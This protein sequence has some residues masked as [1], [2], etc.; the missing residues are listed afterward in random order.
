MA[1]S[2]LAVV[3][4]FPEEG[5]PSMD[6]CANMLLDQL[7]MSPNLSLAPAR[8][9]P[10]FCRRF[11]CFPG[12]G[13]KPFFFNADRLCNRHWDFPRFLKGNVSRFEF[14]HIVDHSYAH[15]VHELP[16][17]RTGVYC[18]D[19]DAFRCLLRPDLEPRSRWFRRLARQKL[20]GLQRAAVVFH[21]TLSVRQEIL[22][23]GLVESQRLVHAPNGVCPEYMTNPRPNDRDVIA[24][25]HD[26][27]YLLHVG[28]C[29]PRKRIDVLLDVFAAVRRQHPELRLVKVGGPWTSTQQDQIGR[30]GIGRSIV[31]FTDVDRSSLAALYRQAAVLL[32]P[33]EA[34]GFGLPVIEGLACGSVVIASDLPVLREVG[35]DAVLYCPV[36]DIASWTDMVHSVIDRPESVPG[37]SVRLAR[38]A[39]YSWQAQAR[40]IADAYLRLARGG[41]SRGEASAC[42][43]PS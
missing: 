12:F 23:H 30:L 8:I 42:A 37:K 31:Q 3:C 19:L 40:T 36:G 18:H 21:T 7:V 6:L 33:S 35:G 20:D 24:D 14:F 26:S 34:E 5:W 39:R 25:L 22:D 28:S 2:R 29:I 4:D 9:C 15:L 16:A 41:Q 38:A 11:S 17:E 10:P 1:Q 43:S 13:R 27:P 32:L